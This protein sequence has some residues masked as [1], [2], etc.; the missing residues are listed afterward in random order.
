MPDEEEKAQL[1]QNIQIALQAGGIDLEDAIDLREIKN[2]KLANQMLKVKR[3]KKQ[4]K[5]RQL[6]LQNI[7]AQA[8]ANA[9]AAEKSALAEAQK[10]QVIAES[11]IQIEQAKSQL[12]IQRMQNESKI[13]QD[14]MAL[15]FS[16]NTKLA[17]MKVER[18]K[19][20]EQFIEDRK[21]KRTKLASSQQSEMI[22]QR[23]QDG[24]PINFDAKY[25]DLLSQ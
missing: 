23:Q 4:E 13:K 15:E 25:S 19:Q 18:E 2:I 9:E 7:Q 21:D 12:E 17:Q 6:Q 10:Q 11:T 22:S 8:Q 1:E 14:L 24:P 16:Y 20:R 3:R 5:E